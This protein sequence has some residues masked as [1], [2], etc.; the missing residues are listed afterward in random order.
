[1]KLK[2]VMP[3]ILILV[4]FFM[5]FSPFA[6]PR[7]GAG[8]KYQPPKRTYRSTATRRSTSYRRPSSTYT[9]TR[10]GTS[11]RYSSTYRTSTHYGSGTTGS[12]GSGAGCCGVFTGCGMLGFVGTVIVVVI[13]LAVIGSLIKKKKGDG[14][15]KPSGGGSSGG[16]MYAD[17]HIE[18]TPIEMDAIP[19]IDKDKVNAQM[20]QFKKKDEFFSEKVFLDKAQTAFF[21]IQR[22][23]SR[24]D[25]EPVRNRM[26]EA[27]FNR[28]EMQVSEYRDKGWNNKVED[29]VIG[30]IAI[31]DMGIEGEYDFVETLIKASMSDKTYNKEGKIVE[32]SPK[33]IP[34][35][36]YWTFVRKQGARTNTDGGRTVSHNCPSCGAPVEAGESGKCPYCDVTLTTGSFDWVLDTITQVTAKEDYGGG[37]DGGGGGS[38]DDEY[39]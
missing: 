6:Y 34:M 38:D 1:M 36:E 11:T 5:F 8:H 12:K 32:G 22:A 23:W 19:P 33:I 31:N 30:E 37:Y 9:S 15:G 2:K 39:V 35:A 7:A 10:Y 18:N 3:L 13:I 29:I 20:E 16:G 17:N 24:N 4:A 21:E 27:Q 14:G 25:L 26:S 28:M